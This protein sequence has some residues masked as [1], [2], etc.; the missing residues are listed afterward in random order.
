MSLDK[1]AVIFI[2][3]ILPISIVLQVYTNYQVQTI[4]LQT[5]YDEKLNAA[6]KDAIKAYQLNAFNESTSDLSVS[7]MRDIKAAANA[8]F[9]SISASFNMDSYNK[10]VL[11]DYVPALVFTMYDGYY[12]YSKY[13][14]TLE[15]GLYTKD[16]YTDETGR[17]IEPST[18]YNDQQVYGVNPFVSYSCRYTYGVGNTAS[19]FVISYT[20]DN[21]ISIQGIVNGKWIHDA[22]YV[23]DTSKI[24]YNPSSNEIVYRGKSIK[25]EPILEEKVGQKIYKY[26]KVNGVKYYY[27]DEHKNSKGDVEPKWF[28]LI[29]GDK[30]YNSINYGLYNDYSA[31]NYYKEALDFTNRLINEYGLTNLSPND[32]KDVVTVINEQTQQE[33]DKKVSELLDQADKDKPIFGSDSS[34]A[35]GIEEPA[36]MFNQHRLA[37]IKFTIER[38]LSIAIKNYNNFSGVSTD[39]QMPKLNE[40]EW[41]KIQHNIT[42]I[43]FL[44]GMSIGGK[45]Y[46][47]CCV[48]PNNKNDEVVTEESIYIANK[49]NNYY[50]NPLYHEFDGTEKLN[51]VFNIDLERRSIESGDASILPDYFYPQEYYADYD[52]IVNPTKNVNIYADP[53]DVKEDTN[54]NYYAYDGNIYKYMEENA[55]PNT[56]TAY[57]TGLGRERNSTYKINAPYKIPQGAKFYERNQHRYYLFDTKSE[58]LKAI[59]NNSA[60]TW[61]N[62][63]A[64]CESLGGHLVTIT[65]EDREYQFLKNNFDIDNST[66]FW[67]GIEVEGNWVTKEA[68]ETDFT[69]NNA[70]G[71]TSGGTCQYFVCEWE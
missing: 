5:S 54:N 37:V 59:F 9:N 53:K 29:N 52:S 65:N 19:D 30:A 27:D 55:K 25:P 43:S 63:E 41:D 46:N 57:F 8:F 50:Y 49:N 13:T 32:A 61:D 10:E 69:I 12:I 31:Y 38:Y 68:N 7:K 44:Q 4:N 47:G 33:E 51:G 6:T 40:T 39:F 14:N 67:V 11:E 21:Y 60:I 3:I 71:K 23:I 15:D 66:E 1:L 45:V 34:F 16:S 20:L 56:A 35:S 26:K 36:S 64:Y 22:G 62:A 2:I 28:S 58:E 24:S 48:V 17:T 70:K 18:Y 42:L